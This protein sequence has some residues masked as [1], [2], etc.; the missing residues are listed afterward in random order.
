MTSPAQSLKG[1]MSRQRNTCRRHHS[2]R[3]SPSEA[4]KVTKKGDHARRSACSED[5]LYCPLY[6]WTHPRTNRLPLGPA[7]QHQ[8][9]VRASHHN[10]PLAARA[11][12]RLPSDKISRRRL[13]LVSPQRLLRILKTVTGCPR[14]Q[15]FWAEI[16]ALH[17]PSLARRS[18]VPVTSSVAESTNS[19][20]PL[21]WHYRFQPIWQL[22]YLGL[23]ATCVAQCPYDV[24]VHRQTLQ[25]PEED[26]ACGVAKC[27]DRI[28]SG[29]VME[30]ESH[31]ELR[32]AT[33][34][35]ELEQSSV[36]RRT[37]G[38]RRRNKRRA[39]QSPRIFVASR[40]N[41]LQRWG[42]TGSRRRTVGGEAFD[43]P[44]Y[45]DIVM[46]CPG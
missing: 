41:V 37:D 21:P 5:L 17:V 1:S 12:R 10:A 11:P 6:A 9:C 44:E 25:V 34:R 32:A 20:A 33:R 7:L 15:R 14:F 3:R 8:R 43:S 30:L 4:C 13:G 24:A 45:D 28:L 26:V 19:V 22:D 23:V 36:L 46:A 40:H 18:R 31:K 16:C 27:E 2:I 39:R 35:V 29:Y 42:R 38:R